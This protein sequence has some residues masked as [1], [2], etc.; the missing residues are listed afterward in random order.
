MAPTKPDMLVATVDDVLAVL[1]ATKDGDYLGED[2]SQ[3]EHCLQAADLATRNGDDDETVIAALLHDIG[4]ILPVDSQRM[5][6]SSGGNVGRVGHE[7]IG[8][9]FLAQ[10]GFGEKV[11]TLVGG[12]V[13]AKRYLS[14]EHDYYERLSDASKHSLKFQ[15]GPYTDAE[16]EKFKQTP[17]WKDVVSMRRYD[18]D[19]KVPNIVVPRPVAYRQMMMT[20]LQN[21]AS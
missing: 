9:R 12:H 11:C 8:A 5:L 19:A 10:Q 18:D 3:L 2:I 14:R 1:E 15:G 13:D 6:M 21:V 20:H 4:Q 7:T 16:S 17:Y